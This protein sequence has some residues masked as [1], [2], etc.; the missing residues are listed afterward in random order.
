MSCLCLCLLGPAEDGTRLSL[1]GDMPRE[2]LGVLHF[3]VSIL[4]LVVYKSEENPI[5]P[6]LIE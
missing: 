4:S 2:A 3:K 1:G 6:Q 5:S